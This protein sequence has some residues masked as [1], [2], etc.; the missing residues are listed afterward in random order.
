M[1]I[2]LALLL[3][4]WTALVFQR[5]AAI[6]VAVG[7]EPDDLARCGSV[8]CSIFH[9]GLA[10]CVIGPV[11]EQSTPRALTQRPARRRLWRLRRHG[12]CAGIISME[13]R[14]A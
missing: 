2:L 10:Q 6:D 5:R 8:G 13:T 1:S 11:P 12:A 14:D 7:A 9:F 3:I 4:I